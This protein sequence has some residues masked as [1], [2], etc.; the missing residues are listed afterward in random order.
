MK[1]CPLCGAEAKGIRQNP[2]TEVSSVV[3]RRCGRYL[4]TEEAEINVQT[5][6][7]AE[8]VF[9]SAATRQE[10]EAGRV[11]QLTDANIDKMGKERA[12]TS[13]PENVDKLLSYVR[14]KCPRPGQR[15]RIDR[16]NDYTVIDAPTPAELEYITGYAMEVD[17]L[18]YTPPGDYWL[19][20]KGW[21]R[22]SARPSVFMPGRCFV[23]MAFRDS[24]KPA[25]TEGIQKAVEDDC[26]FRAVRMLELEHNDK[27]C[28]RIIVEVRR[29]QFVVA[30]FTFQRAGV[31]FEAGFAAALE[32]PVIWTCKACHFNRLHFDTRQYNH[33][34]WEQPDD[35]RAQLATRI[36]GTIPGAKLA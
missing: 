14:T 15:V 24:L 29:A 34:K 18:R 8:R 36:R 5:M 16:E 32:R 35:L 30:D 12:H 23:A 25:Y 28:D 1:A 21:E 7:D 11:V 4:I 17:Y 22:I 10:T 9:L 6:R 33:I 20:P 27:I 2:S 26:G 31:Y 19:T 13:I 3:C